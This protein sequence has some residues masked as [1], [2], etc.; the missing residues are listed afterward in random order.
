MAGFLSRCSLHSTRQSAYKRLNEKRNAL[1]SNWL[2]AQLV[3]C[4]TRFCF[5]TAASLRTLPHF[6]PTSNQKAGA[7]RHAHTHICLNAFTNIVTRMWCLEHMYCCNR[8]RFRYLLTGQ[9]WHRLYYVPVHVSKSCVS[10]SVNL[11]LMQFC[12]PVIGQTK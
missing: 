2:E 4:T 7:D 1:T 5:V 6:C 12:I 11:T 9:H 8:K 3:L 10:M